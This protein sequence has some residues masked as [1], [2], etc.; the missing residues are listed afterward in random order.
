MK[1]S[2]AKKAA[3]WWADQLRNGAKLDNG[4]KSD[5]GFTTHMLATLAQSNRN[6]PEEK[7][8]LFENSLTK[9]V[10]D[11]KM[12]TVILGCDYHPDRQL[13]LASE[14]AGI[15]V[16]MTDFPW[17]TTMWIKDDVVEVSEGYGASSV[18]I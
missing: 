4:D 10:L 9:F 1:S 11:E 3:K 2:T 7:I 8:I 17:K 18:K 13:L 16:G 6:I 14:E 15:E 12:T 5:A